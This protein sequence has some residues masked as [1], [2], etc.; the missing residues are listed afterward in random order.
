[1]GNKRAEA[2]V[3]HVEDGNSFERIEDLGV[4]FSENVV[5]KILSS[6]KT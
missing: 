1:V 6:K 2:I 4:L 5:K 3:K